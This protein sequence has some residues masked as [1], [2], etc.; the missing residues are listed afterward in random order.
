[1]MEQV[2]IVKKKKRSPND[3]AQMLNGRG[4]AGR[5]DAIDNPAIEEVKVDVSKAL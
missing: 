4:V 3:M 2:E 5:F 1:M